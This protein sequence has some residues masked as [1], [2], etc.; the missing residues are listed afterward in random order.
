ML[1]G[2]ATEGGGTAGLV[3]ERYEDTQDHQEDQDAHVVA[4][5]E[6]R[7]HAVVE[8][9]GQGALKA[10]VSI[11]EP[12]HHDAHEQGGVD[13]LGDEGQADGDDGW[14]QR[15]EGLIEAGGGLSVRFVLGEG[16]GGGDEEEQDQEGQDF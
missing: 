14:E 3:H 9:V 5:G 6:G 16:E 10:E 13:L 8:D 4:V 11:E 7:H 12:A 15:P 1:G 2:P